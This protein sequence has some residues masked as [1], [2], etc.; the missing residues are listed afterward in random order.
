MSGEE[1]TLCQHIILGFDSN[2][3][4]FPLIHSDKETSDSHFQLFSSACLDRPL[5]LSRVMCVCN[6][7]NTHQ[8]VK[9]LYAHSTA[10]TVFPK[11]LRSA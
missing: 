6:P 2:R 1:H 8:G 10:E 11:T 5:E 4:I 9:F 7:V 3:N